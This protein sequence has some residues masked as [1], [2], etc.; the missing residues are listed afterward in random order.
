MLLL[1]GRLIQDVLFA[2]ELRRTRESGFPFSPSALAA[3][4]LLI[5]GSI[6]AVGI[7]F[8]VSFFS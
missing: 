4:A 7:A 5:T 8:D 1:I 3:V 6:A 2:R